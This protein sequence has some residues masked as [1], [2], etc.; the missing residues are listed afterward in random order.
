MSTL[1]SHWYSNHS[2]LSS[3]HTSIVR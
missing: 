2:T 1:T 3:R